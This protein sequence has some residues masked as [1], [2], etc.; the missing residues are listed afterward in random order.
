M[1]PAGSMPMKQAGTRP[2]VPI[3]AGNIVDSNAA[4]M[5]RL[6]RPVGAGRGA[7]GAG[8]GTGG[9]AGAGGGGSEGGPSASSL[10]NCNPW[11]RLCDNLLPWRILSDASSAS[12]S[13]AAAAAATA[14]A[15]VEET[16]SGA[17][18]IPILFKSEDEYVSRWEESARAE[19]KANILS[20]LSAET[21]SAA[22]GIR[23]ELAEVSEQG[24]AVLSLSKLSCRPV[25]RPSEDRSQPRDPTLGNAR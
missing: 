5:K 6:R 14:T 17:A 2:A 10:R 11:T 23:A 18:V 12:S 20:G 22:A 13:S 4:P 19:L 21:F 9:S 8:R 1:K 3:F 24:P 25:G 7:G 16:V 15:N